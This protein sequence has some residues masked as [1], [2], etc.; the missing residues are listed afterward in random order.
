METLDLKL[1]LWGG[2]PIEAEGYGKIKPLLIK[3]VIDFGYTDY[4][5]ML[6]VICLEKEDLFGEDAS[7][8][9]EDVTVLDLLIALGGEDLESKLEQALSLFL[10]GKAVIDKEELEI[11]VKYDDGEVKQVNRDNY[12]N[13]V[14]TI[15]WQNFVNQFDDKNLN[16]NFNP[17][18]EKARKLKER[19]EKLNKE[20][21]RIKNKR[22]DGEDEN[23]DIDFYDILSAVSSKS[24]STNELDL[25][26]YTIFEVYTKFKRLEIIDQYNISIKSIMAGGKDVKLKHWSTKA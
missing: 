1:K 22:E 16:S 13:I 12:K 2:L 3:E 23:Q 26:D 15:K 20:R 25:L 19:M 10:G 4:M 7:H 14:E 21:E 24:N 18:D 8:I 5:N 11:L 17:A 9:G 6:N